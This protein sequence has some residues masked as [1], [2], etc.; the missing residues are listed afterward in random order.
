MYPRHQYE[1]HQEQSTIEHE[2]HDI[3][4]PQQKEGGGHAQGMP[5][6]EYEAG[7]NDYGGGP[8]VT[9]L[10]PHFGKHV[11]CRIWVDANVSI[12]YFFFCLFN[13]L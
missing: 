9:T 4:Q 10:L 7:P 12:F 5:V 13:L 6:V 2:Q 11:A 8:S 1:D 3:E